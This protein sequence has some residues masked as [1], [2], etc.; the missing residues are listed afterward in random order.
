MKKLFY[1]LLFVSHLV[2]AQVPDVVKEMRT[3]PATTPLNSIDFG[4]SNYVQG[5]ATMGGFVYFFAKSC[6]TF[7]YSL[8]KSDGTAAGT[9]EIKSFPIIGERTIHLL[10]ATATKVFF[11]INW[12]KSEKQTKIP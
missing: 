11:K 2:D 3:T 5:T 10:G 9:Q 8:Y 12:P 4:G 1:I 7:Y 6:Q